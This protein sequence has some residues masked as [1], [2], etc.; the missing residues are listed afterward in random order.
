[1]ARGRWLTPNDMPTAYICRRLFI[2]AGQE[3]L[4]IVSGCLSELFYPG[5]F[6]KDGAVSAEDTAAMFSQMY[7]GYL[8]EAECISMIGI[9][10]PCAAAV[11]P[12]NC[13][14]CDGSQ[15]T[16]VAYPALY[17]VLDSAFIIDA[18]NFV[19]PDLRGRMIVGVGS[20]SGLTP[21]AMGDTGGQ[22]TH[23]LS[24][25]E[26]AAHNHTVTGHIHTTHSHLAAVAV[27]PGELPVSTPNVVPELTGTGSEGINNAGSGSAHENMTPFV[28]LRYVIVAV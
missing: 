7:L 22:E 9:I 4:A 27:A 19:V 24:V 8:Q 5:S 1:M 16:R 28:A 17:A 18:D 11:I 26:L 14:E 13:L 10:L 6:E 25:A 21:R 12:T 23:A 20:G 2:P 15:Y 3:W